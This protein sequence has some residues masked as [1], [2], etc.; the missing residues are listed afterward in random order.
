[1]VLK[2]GTKIWYQNMAR[3]FMVLDWKRLGWNRVTGSDWKKFPIFQN[4]QKWKIPK[5]EKIISLK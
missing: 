3:G 1:M 4:F 2:Y 5:M